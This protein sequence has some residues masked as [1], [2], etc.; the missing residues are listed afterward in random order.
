MHTEDIELVRINRNRPEIMRW[1]RQNEP[2]TEEQQNYWWNKE[3]YLGN[4]FH[5]MISKDGLDYGYC[6]L[7]VDERHGSAEFSI[8]SF[9]KTNLGYFGLRELLDYGF[10]QLG[11]NR[12]HSDVIENN[13]AL[14]LYNLMGFKN[15]GITRKAYYKNGEW[16]NATIIGLLREEYV[17]NSRK[18]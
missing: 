7:R 2:L 13:P 5:F 8:I 1:L 6:A 16:Q 15:E 12:I 14:K 18:R 17:P 10:T 11:L 9:G 4:H 3:R